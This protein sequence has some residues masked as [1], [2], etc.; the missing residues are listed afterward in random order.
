MTRSR[1]PMKL[2]IAAASFAALGLAAL[3]VQAVQEPSA[4]RAEAEQ[5]RP[6][7]SALVLDQK[8]DGN[9]VNLTYAYMPEDGFIAI[10]KGMDGAASGKP[11]GTA[12]L[13]AGDHRDVKVKL[14][15][16]VDSGTE[17]FVSLAKGRGDAYDE[18]K[19]ESVW[20]MGEIPTESRFKVL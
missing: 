5:S 1:L 18:S 14:S 2:S 3:P 15:T 20:Q 7:P 16:S 8:L 9:T 19:H 13:P 10:Y 4:T 11:I 6:H 12:A 17:L